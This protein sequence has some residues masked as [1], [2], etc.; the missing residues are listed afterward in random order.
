MKKNAGD[1]ECEKLSQKYTWMG[2]SFPEANFQ[3][4]Q[5]VDL[6]EI[7]YDQKLH[8]ETK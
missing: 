8:Q 6:K 4:R 5:M 7:S 1:K 3:N 2:I